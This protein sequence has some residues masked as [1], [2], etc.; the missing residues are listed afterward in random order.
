MP[1]AKAPYTLT[2]RLPFRPALDTSTHATL[3]DLF[4]ALA[5]RSDQLQLEMDQGKE[6]IM[7]LSFAD[8]GKRHRMI[9]VIT[10]QVSPK[11]NAQEVVN[12]AART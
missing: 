6:F 5:L 12:R 3:K 10:S 1:K 2:L 8:S 9:A 11:R 7:S 4:V